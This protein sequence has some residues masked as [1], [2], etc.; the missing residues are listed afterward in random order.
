MRVLVTGVTGYIGSHA[1]VELLGAG[2][3]VIGV[4][5]FSASTIETR[6]AIER[7]A[8]RKIEFH[9][10]DLRDGKGVECLLGHAELDAILHFAGR[11]FVGESVANPIRYYT[12]NVTASVNLFAAA[13]RNAINNVVF[14]SSC[15]V[16]GNPAK[17][18]VT[19]QSQIAPVSPYGRT[20]AVVEGL[21]QDLC[22]AQPKMRALA[23]RYFNPIGAHPSGLIGEIPWGTPNNLV[24]YVMEVA[25]GE[26]AVLSVFG[27]DYNTPDGTCVRDYVHVVDIAKAH[28]LALE[29]VRRNTFGNRFE[30]RDG[31]GAL[32]LGTGHGSSVLEVLDA[33]R[34]ATQRP[35]A[36]QVVARRPGDAAVIY[37]DPTRAASELG[38]RAELDLITMCTDHWNFAQ[39]IAEQQAD[40]S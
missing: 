18:P 20:K 1:A 16:Y 39:N 12:R 19:E 14:S 38:W 36:H 29:A 11:K 7:A 4:D 23:L 2:H 25:T 32:N 9:E 17:L 34:T 37:A 22:H 33:C 31:F 30:N 8:G 24:P 10:L 6:Q 5:D 3:D 40:V 26:R 28:V 13:E 35:I 21:L 15:T 27:D